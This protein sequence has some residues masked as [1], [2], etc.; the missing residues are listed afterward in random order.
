MQKNTVRGR[1][2]QK[3]L[4]EQFSDDILNNMPRR[5]VQSIVPTTSN[6]ARSL[7][8]DHHYINSHNG[9]TGLL[10]GVRERSSFYRDGTSLERCG[11]AWEDG[12]SCDQHETNAKTRA[13]RKCLVIPFPSHRSRGSVGPS[14]SESN[15]LDQPPMLVHTERWCSL[16]T[17]RAFREHTHP[18]TTRTPSYHAQHWR[19]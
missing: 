18:R 19:S 3:N 14:L 11:A 5:R 12:G 13:R 4:C 2:Q 8:N 10:Q 9:G 17:R 1:E 16:P 7:D 15:F 6:D